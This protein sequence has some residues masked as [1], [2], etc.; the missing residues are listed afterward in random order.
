MTDQPPT[1]DRT[2]YCHKIR[3]GITGAPILT[4]DEMDGT[5]APG[6][7]VR[8][9]LIELVYSPAR[10]GKPARINASVTGDWM[11]FGKPDPFG[12]QATTHFKSGP[13][14]WPAWLAEEARLHDPAPDAASEATSAPLRPVHASSASESA[15]SPTG[16]A[17]GAPRD[18]GASVVE[19]E[20]IHLHFGLSYANYLVLPRTLL[21]S[22]DDRWQTEFVALLDQLCEAFRHVPQADAYKVEAAEEHTVSEMSPNQLKQAGITEDWYGGEIPPD[23]L[24][25]DDLAEWQN[26]HEQLSPDYYDA[27]GDELDEHGRVLIPVADPVPHYNR[28]RTRIEPA[29][30]ETHVVADDSSDPEHVDDC[31]G[32]ATSA[33]TGGDR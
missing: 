28:G 6:V 31:P 22:M 5:F 4:E 14:G 24:A 32:C 17:E 25:P 3:Y 11:R 9:T 15:Q 33:T 19:T 12:G 1:V 29:I 20:A 26:L 2:P 13:D 21:Q 18:S 10:D 30:E 16:A 27:D 23:G 8:P 7:G